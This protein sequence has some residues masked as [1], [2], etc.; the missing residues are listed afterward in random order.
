M[1]EEDTVEKK[2]ARAGI[3]KDE[4][5]RPNYLGNKPNKSKV[6]VIEDDVF[7]VGST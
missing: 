6:K 1:N 5:K 7:E 4:Q 3:T 2:T